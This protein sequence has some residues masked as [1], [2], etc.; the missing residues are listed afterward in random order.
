[1]EYYKGYK[2]R[3]LAKLFSKETLYYRY[4]LE[5][6]KEWL[7]KAAPEEDW[8]EIKMWGLI[9]QFVILPLE[10]I[11]IFDYLC[12][13]GM[14]PSSLYSDSYN[15]IKRLEK[16]KKDPNAKYMNYADEIIEDNKKVLSICEKY[17]TKKQ[18][19]ISLY[20]YELSKYC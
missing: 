9:D 13:L 20:A 14:D 17:M 19:K 12:Q 5:E 18:K 6:F 1:M 2:I 10:D 4:T 8:S 15:Q 11:S 16:K 3:D 7:R